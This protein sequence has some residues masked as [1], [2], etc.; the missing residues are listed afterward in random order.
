MP[1]I[2]HMLLVQMKT[3]EPQN[4]SKVTLPSVE[5][6]QHFHKMEIHFYHC[7]LSCLFWT[8]YQ[9]KLSVIIGKLSLPKET[10][11]NNVLQIMQTDYD[12]PEGYFIIHISKLDILHMDA[13]NNNSGKLKQ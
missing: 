12:L 2:L 7:L 11:L 10:N 9:V 1:G 8:W 5:F 3:A 6:S 4:F 13:L